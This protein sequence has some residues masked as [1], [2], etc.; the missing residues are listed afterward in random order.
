MTH[1]EREEHLLLL[2][3]T[4]VTG[5]IQHPVL[6]DQVADALIVIQKEIN[7]EPIKN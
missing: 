1:E 7:N 6:R 5:T 2:I 4:G 3:A